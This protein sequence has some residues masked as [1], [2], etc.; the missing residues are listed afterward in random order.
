MPRVL[1]RRS[2][3]EK[4][5][6]RKLFREHGRNFWK[7]ANH[8]LTARTTQPPRERRSYGIEK[9][10]GAICWPVEVAGNP[11]RTRSTTERAS[12]HGG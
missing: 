3:E 9:G 12:D 4:V 5:T 6:I 11:T 10:K 2:V 8:R 7:I 1:Q